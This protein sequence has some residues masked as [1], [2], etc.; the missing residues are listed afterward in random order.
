MAALTAHVSDCSK[1]I[2]DLLVA[3]AIP[4]GIEDVW[5]GDQALLPHTPAACVESGPLNKELIGMPSYT[6]NTLT[7]YIMLY[8]SALKD[9]QATTREAILYAESIMSLLHV[10]L[11]LGGLVI[12]G[13]VRAIEPG[14]ADKGRSWYRS[15]R[16][17]WTGVSRTQLHLEA[18]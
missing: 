4:L 18:A 17:T 5:D 7:V 6:E 11:S 15:V 1:A 13:Y 9:Q 2:Y 12:H 3:N 14:Y 10:D 16:I 8:H